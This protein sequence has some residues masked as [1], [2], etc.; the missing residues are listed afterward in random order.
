MLDNILSSFGLNPPDYQIRMFGSGLINHTL[1]VSGKGEA[2]IL[3]QINPAVFKSP[4]SIANNLAALQTYLKNTCPAYLFVGALPSVSGDFLV[5]SATGA[6]YRLLPFVKNSKTLL[7]INNEKEAFEAAKQFGKFTRLLKDFDVGRLEYTLTDFH[8]LTLR[9]EQFEAACGSAS[10]E[11]TKHA[12]DEIKE[13]YRH[14]DILHT[15]NQLI[16][17]N[18]IPLRVI[19]HDTKISNVLFDSRQNGLCVIDLDTV[20]PGY[21]FSDVGDMMRTYLSRANEEET[22]LSKINIR[23]NIFSAICR[24][25]LSEMGSLLTKTEKQY[26]IFSGSLM[27]Y[28]QAMRFLTDYLNND[29]YYTVAYE[30]QNLN[31]ARNQFKL[32][33]EYTLAEKKLRL[34]MQDAEDYCSIAE[35]KTNKTSH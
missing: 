10:A 32:L 25:Y 28:M 15:Y 21:F 9:F 18:K 11:R 14:L 2:Y 13:A 35:N 31:R 22:D 26:F 5:K 30:G 20:M 34:L 29:I 6:F 12:S 33:Q 3:Q 19:H 23:E 8:N 17:E 7:F 4:Q 16:A 1:K 24:G 27:I